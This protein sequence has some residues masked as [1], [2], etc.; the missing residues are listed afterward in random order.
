LTVA[1]SAG[2][3]TPLSAGFSVV[4][5]IMFMAISS[6]LDLRRRFGGI[7]R[8][9]LDVVPPPEASRLKKALGFS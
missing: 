8:G 2:V 7:A 3:F 6:V 9:G 4:R 1:S 5:S